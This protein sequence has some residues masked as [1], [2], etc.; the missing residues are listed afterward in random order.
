MVRAVLFDLDGTL[1]DIDLERFLERYFAALRVVA[2]ETAGPERADKVME[3]IQRAVRAMM[4]PHPMLTNRAVFEAEYERISGWALGG[5][6]PAYERFYAEVF[7]TLA[8]AT[9]PIPG[10]REAI[11]TA[12][13]LGLSVAV[14][15]NP[16]FPRAAVD[17]RLAWAGL[18]GLDLP[19]VTTYENMLACKPLPAYFMQVAEMLSVPASDCMMVGDDRYLDMPAADV[20]MRTFYVGNHEDAVATYRGTLHDLAALL[21]RLVATDAV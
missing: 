7:P 17:H 10:A 15:T 20:G 8:D 12:L 4:E 13:E 14:A 1:L 16:I 21:P 3:A 9:G 11:E 19:V 6:W 18:G 2:V 5:V